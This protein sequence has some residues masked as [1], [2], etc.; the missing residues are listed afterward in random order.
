MKSTYMC[1]HRGIYEAFWL[2]MNTSSDNLPLRKALLMSIWRIGQL[3]FTTMEKTNWIVVS[4]TTRR[5]AFEINFGCLM[6]SFGNESSFILLVD[7]SRFF[8][9]LRIHRFPIMF[10]FWYE[11]TRDHVLFQESANSSSLMDFAHFGW[12]IASWTIIGSIE[13]SSASIASKSLLFIYPYPRTHDHGM[14]GLWWS[15]G[16]IHGGQ[17]KEEKNG[18][19]QQVKDY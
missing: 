4:F 2:I 5:N 6:E 13:S 10:I 16:V 7:P 3:C 8:L 15:Y 9:S 14:Y 19:A 1:W 17:W 18:E 11:G 12:V